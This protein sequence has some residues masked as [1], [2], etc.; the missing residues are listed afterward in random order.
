MKEEEYS[1]IN[2]SFE[3]NG[4]T[5]DCSYAIK[6]DIKMILNEVEESHKDSFDKLYDRQSL[7]AD[8]VRL[9]I[10]DR[11]T[12]IYGMII[13]TINYKNQSMKR[14]ACGNY[15]PVWVLSKLAL[16]PHPYQG[17]ICW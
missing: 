3:Y 9:F 4:K 13:Y 14:T 15:Y 8:K 5:Y 2:D 6:R 10:D 16:M 7:K 11:Q 12:P 1:I 17:S